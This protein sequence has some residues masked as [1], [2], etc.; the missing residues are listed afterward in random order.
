M[1]YRRKPTVVRDREIRIPISV[2]LLPTQSERVLDLFRSVD[3][4]LCVDGPVG[5]TKTVQVMLKILR[6]H[7][8]YPGFQSL[9]VRSEAKTLHTTIVPQL[10]TKIFRYH[11]KSKRNPFRLYGGENRAAH[12][13]FDNGG[14]MTFGGMDDSGKILGSEYDLIFYNQAERE[15]YQKNWEDLIGRGLE[16]RAGNWPHSDFG[17][18]R[19]RFQIIADANPSAPTHWL[20]AREVAG[21]IRFISFKHE[22]NPLYYY[23]GDW[24]ERGIRNKEELIKRYT[25]Y[26]RDRFVY[27]LWV[28]AQGI[29]YTMF[30][31]SVEVEE[32]GVKRKVPH[33]V[34]YVDVSDIRDDYDWYCSV[35]YGSVNAFV[36]QLWAVHPNRDR[37]V[38]YKEIYHT[39]LT[40]RT[41]IPM[42]KEMVESVLGLGGRVKTVFTDHDASHNDDLRYAG[43]HVTEADKNV[44]SGIELCKDMLS[45]EYDRPGYILPEPV[46]IFHSNSLYNAPDTKLFGKPDRTVAEFPLYT[47]REESERKGDETDEKPN[48]QYNHGMDAMRY[49]LKGVSSYRPYSMISGH[50]NFKNNML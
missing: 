25:G 21:Q 36:C 47:Y 16:G 41:F 1:K 11:V 33:H 38:L 3:T 45:A 5:C 10:F 23:D 43:F 20:K 49:L 2:S 7:E 39:G 13:D 30:R 4:E 28:A 18:D 35:D 8:R 27:G 32:R 17:Y 37:Y 42:M 46:V 19:P 24:T 9:V 12:L 44:L 6:L 50:A 40:P 34:R 26:M 48:P 14:R 31:D 15:R 29:V 22:D